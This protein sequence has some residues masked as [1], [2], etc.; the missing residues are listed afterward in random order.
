MTVLNNT[1]LKNFYLFIFRQRGREGEREGE[2]YQCV[3]AF[4]VSPAGDLGSKAGMCPQWELNQRP[5][6]SQAGAQ[7]TE[8]HQPGLKQNFKKEKS[9][10]LPRWGREVG[11]V[12]VGWRDGEKRHTT[13]LE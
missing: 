1:F 2:K 13:I 11:S 3:V 8:P 5:S 10:S 7:S 6:G 12:G 4:R 9:P